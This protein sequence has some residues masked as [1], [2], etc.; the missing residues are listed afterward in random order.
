VAELLNVALAGLASGAIY[1]L[2]AMSYNV[3]FATTGVLNFAQGQL[4]MVGAM[5]GY[6]LR[7]VA[8]WPLAAAL[9]GAVLAGAALAAVEEVLAVRP[10]RAG[11][12][13]ALGWVLST[14]GFAIVLQSTFALAFGATIN[15]VPAILSDAPTNVGGVLLVPQ[16]LGLVGLAVAVAILFAVL[17]RGTLLGRALEAVEQDSEAAALRGLP[18]RALATLSFAGGGAIAALAGFAASPLVGAYPA[19]GLIFAL[20]GFVAAAVGGIP[21]M[22]GALLGGLGLG[23][24][25]AFAAQWVGAGYRNAA[26]FATLLLVLAVRP[27]G[28]LGRGAVRAV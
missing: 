1:A 5:V 12:R 8:G 4:L 15:N 24:V 25:E 22:R 6:E 9:V 11:G 10:A 21:D 16:Q 7:V 13:G 20:K 23:I 2:L 18:V 3:I 28:I 17:Y 14:L 26:V 27:V 19:M